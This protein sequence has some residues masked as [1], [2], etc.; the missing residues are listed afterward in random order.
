MG[1]DCLNVGCVPSK[2]LLRAARA[3]A[4]VR[5]AREF[6]VDVPPGDY[7]LV[8]WHVVTGEFPCYEPVGDLSGP[9]SVNMDAAEVTYCQER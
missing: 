2:A 7:D 4:G 1:G 6:G 5:D 3:L 8:A 9:N